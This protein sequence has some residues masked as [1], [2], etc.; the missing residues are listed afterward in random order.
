MVF[1]HKFEVLKHERLDHDGNVFGPN[2]EA[3]DVECFT[4]PL[5]ECVYSFDTI[6]DMLTHLRQCKKRI[7]KISVVLC[8]IANVKLRLIL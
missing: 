1:Q 5:D 3:E 8:V 7:P 2:E 6:V 4:C